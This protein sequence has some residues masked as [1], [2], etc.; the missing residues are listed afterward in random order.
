M[1]ELYDLLAGTSTGSLLAATL[2]I[3]NLDP[4]TNQTQKNKYWAQTGL[5]MYIKNGA[6]VFQR[7]EVSNLVLWLGVAIFAIIGGALGFLL[8]YSKFHNKNTEDT[9]KAFQTLIHSR[10][11]QIKGK[12]PEGVNGELLVSAIAMN[13]SQ[14]LEELDNGQFLSKQIQNGGLPDLQE[15]EEVLLKKKNDY[16]ERQG[17][18]WAFL[19]FG[20]LI[21][22]VIGYV[23]IPYFFMLTTSAYSRTGVEVLSAEIFGNTTV[24]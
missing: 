12:T 4:A 22:A 16:H 14:R 2:V 19:A 7:N 8:G 23:S 10:K 11:Q 6:E 1:A 3:P 20:F 17:F 21:A 9:L 5:D 15:A 18:K 24:D 13:I